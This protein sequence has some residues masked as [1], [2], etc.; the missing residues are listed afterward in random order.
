MNRYSGFVF[1]FVLT[2][3][4]LASCTV[5][6]PEIT[7]TGEKTVLEKQL[8]GQYELSPKEIY[9]PS[10]DGGIYSLK[11]LGSRDSVSEDEIRLLELDPDRKMYLIARANQRFNFDDIE[12]FKEMRVIGE[13]NNGYLHIFDDRKMELSK[14]DRAVLDIVVDEENSGRR[15][16]MSRIIELQSDLT[17]E[18]FPRIESIFAAQNIQQEKPGRMVQR[19][20]GQWMVKP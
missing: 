9:M 19:P 2:S 13:S 1:L 11:R 7:V 18:D 15:I 8:L 17:M 3:I 10:V 20:D 16:I 12:R 14:A 6:P 5:K 4:F